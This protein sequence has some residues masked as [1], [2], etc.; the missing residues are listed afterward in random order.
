MMKI[1]FDLDNTIANYDVAVEKLASKFFNTTQ[2]F[3][4]KNKL[5]SW[6]RNNQKNEKWTLFQGFLYGPGMQLVDPYPNALEQIARLKKIGC[7]LCIISHKTKSPYKGKKYRLQ[8]H[9]KNW[10]MNKVRYHNALLFDEKNVFFELSVE[11][12]IKR[13]S[14]ENLDAFIDD[15]P[16]VLG[17]KE[18]PTKPKKILFNPGRLPNIEEYCQIFNWAQLEEVL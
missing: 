3:S 2:I 17:H 5:K 9:A 13:I 7:K 8:I 16:L 12:K 10:I 4:T 18:F 14:D 11:K 6:C 15:L 1:G